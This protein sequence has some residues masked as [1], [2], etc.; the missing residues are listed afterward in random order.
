MSIAMLK[1]R[2][3]VEIEI[4]IRQ[5]NYSVKNKNFIKTTNPTIKRIRPD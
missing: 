1:R 2:I 3:T 5:K 4:S